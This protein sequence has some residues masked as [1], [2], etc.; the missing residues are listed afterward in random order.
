[1]VCD[2]IKIRKLSDDDILS[3]QNNF[4]KHDYLLFFLFPCLGTTYPKVH[5]KCMNI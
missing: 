1:M 5:S 2:C 4:N 3:V